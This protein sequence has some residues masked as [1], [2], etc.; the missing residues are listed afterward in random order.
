VIGPFKSPRGGIVPP[1]HVKFVCTV[2]PFQSAIAVA[3]LADDTV[4]LIRIVP[5]WL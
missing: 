3:A 1:E 5:V 4:K 2:L